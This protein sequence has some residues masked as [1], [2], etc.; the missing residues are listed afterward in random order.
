MKTTSPAQLRTARRLGLFSASLFTLLA[1]GPTR[2]A[3][4]ETAKPATSTATIEVRGDVP[5]PGPL[6]VTDLQAL[7][8]ATF[9]WVAHGQSHTVL[10]VPLS[11]VL[12]R[13]GWEPGVMGKNIAAADKRVGYKRVIVATAP[14][15]FQAVFSAAELAPAM[16][17]TQAVLCWMIDGKPLP[18]AEGPLRLVVLTDDEPSR[19]IYHLQRLDVVDMRRIVP[20][21]PASP[22]PP[23][24]P[25]PAGLSGSH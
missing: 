25:P 1:L 4:A 10:G 6:S 22:A 16:G 11:T 23:G 24:S 3:H 14:D 13:F 9:T 15:G 18:A 20:A 8:P 2:S 21:S 12:R 19:S 7:S 17:K 5:K